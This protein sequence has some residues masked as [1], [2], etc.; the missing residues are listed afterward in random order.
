MKNLT[1]L[2]FAQQMERQREN[3]SRFEIYRTMTGE[4]LPAPVVVP[5][6]ERVFVTV[7]DTDDLLQWL[8][9]YGGAAHRSSPFDGM[10]TWT[11]HQVSDGWTDGHQV[12]VQIS[13]VAQEDEPVMHELLDALVATT[14]VV[15][16]ANSPMAVTA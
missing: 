9:V 4:E 3:R 2:T 11:L 6:P 8:A 14:P 16:L 5:T 13:C 1:D 10:H 15:P 12:P 7:A